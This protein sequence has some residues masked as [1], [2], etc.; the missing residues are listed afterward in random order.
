M[1]KFS[2]MKYERPDLEKLKK[3]LAGLTGELKAAGSY[4]EAREVFL[5]WEEAEK[6]QRTAS[7][8]AR[9]RHSIDT[10]DPF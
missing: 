8:L 2:E 9:V 5:R 4:E 10:R 6:R 3:E 7:T 1:I